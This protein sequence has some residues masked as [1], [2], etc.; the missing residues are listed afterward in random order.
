MRRSTN[1]KPCGCPGHGQ[2]P[3]SRRDLL[4]LSANGFGMLALSA[5]MADR[6][7][8]GA[9][10]L[11]APHFTPKA[12]NVIFLFMDGGVSHVDSFDPKPKLDELDDQSAGKVE[13]IT[14]GGN[15]KWLKC[16]WSF[17]Q[18]GQS[19]MPISELFPHTAE[20]ADDLAVIRSMKGEFPL[21]S[22]GNLL[23]HTGRNTGGLPSVGSWVTYGLG[24][25]N[26]DLPGF[27]VLNFGNT[28]PAGG[29]ENFSS[30]IL[31]ASYQASL[32][33]ATGTPIDNLVRSDKTTELQQAKLRL[34]Q[35]QDQDFAGSIGSS[36]A[37]ESAIRNY[38]LAY[39]M[40]SLVPD[41]LDLDKES[42]ATKQMYGIDSEDESK[43]LYGVQCLRARR[44]IEAGV[45]FV[46][47][48]CPQLYGSTG[49]WDQHGDLKK[50]HEKNA[51]VTDQAVAALIKDLKQ[52]GMFE[53]TLILW[54]G[55]FGRTPHSA[56]RDGRDHHPEGFTVWL[57]GGGIKGG[58]IYGATDEL[59]MHA[60]ED[61]TTIHD[62]HATMLHVLG[63]DHERLTYRFG[64]RDFRLTD[65]YGR[66]V[67]EVLR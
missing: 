60:V 20:Y 43:R 47:V 67:K 27:V 41:V 4:R 14:A 48:C 44:M 63:L 37:V 39:R 3:M 21:H 40:Q 9:S 53:D 38:E 16:P 17:K 6:A 62:L 49:T 35:A 10:P 50:G 12:K 30:G 66:V 22:R 1:Q 33:K 2:A 5:L 19:G 45:R 29:L 23:L 46:E 64:G 31:P 58:T 11:A 32:L 56:G 24:T 65:V 28:V 7:Y 59:G 55:E 25:E 51:M 42:E 57:A 52:R 13:N 26:K 34:L 18:Y 61:V 54:A 15:R 36:E 8:A